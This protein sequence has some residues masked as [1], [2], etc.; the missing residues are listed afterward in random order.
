[1]LLLES[2]LDAIPVVDGLQRLT[3]LRAIDKLDRLGIKGVQQLLGPGRKDESGD[4]TKGAG[5]PIPANNFVTY[6]LTTASINATYGSEL[7][8]RSEIE[9]IERSEKP[10]FDFNVYRKK[11]LDYLGDRP[12]PPSLERGLT[13]LNAIQ[14]LAKRS[15]YSDRIRIDPSVVRGLEYYTGPVF[16]VDL[17]FPIAGDDGKPV[18]F[19][20]VAAGGRYDGLVSRFRGEPV[21]ATGFSIGV[22][23]LAAALATSRQARQ[24]ARARP[25][26]RHRVRQ[27]PPR[28]LPDHGRQAARGEHPRRA[29]SRQPAQSRQSAQI[30][31]QAQRALR[32]HPGHRR[33]GQGR[34]HHQGPDRRRRIGE[35]GKGPRGAFAEAGGGA[36]RRRRGETG[37]RRARGARPPR[38]QF[39]VESFDRQKWHREARR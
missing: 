19:G 39:E 1:M 25:G 24:Q 8:S 30:R 10:P 34:S 38:P 7:I 16:E 31:R 22:S 37:R 9:K 4:F 35:A 29:L 27:G 18:R 3:V 32:G 26:R 2:T 20:S 21:P 6:S 12:V 28:R 17:T 15:G 5:L 33:E 11:I 13:E 14:D 36:V 23:R